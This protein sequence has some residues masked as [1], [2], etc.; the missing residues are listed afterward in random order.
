MRGHASSTQRQLP[1]P[2][3]APPSSPTTAPYALRH[4]V[5]ASTAD[6]DKF[7]V[8]KVNVIKIPHL[9]DQGFGRSEQVERGGLW[10]RQV[11]V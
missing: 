10:L 4:G 2:C 8:E 11:R 9:K 3:A 6:D 5:A 7:T 1:K